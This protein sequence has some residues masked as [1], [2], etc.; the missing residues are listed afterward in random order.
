MQRPK[1]IGNVP[2]DRSLP[3]DRYG[4]VSGASGHEND[5]EK[6]RGVPGNERKDGL[7]PRGRRTG[8]PRK[9]AGAIH[10][11][12]KRWRPENTIFQGSARPAI[13]DG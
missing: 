13:S 2:N 6:A 3:C 7:Q 12:A 8:L 11:G 5:N 1:T 4:R 10:I 9:Q